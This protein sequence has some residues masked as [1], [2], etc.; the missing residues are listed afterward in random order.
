M[1]GKEWHGQGIQPDVPID[2]G[3]TDDGDPQQKKAV[4][5]LRGQ[6]LAADRKAA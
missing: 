4:D 5:Y 3:V 2:G 1:A 6:A